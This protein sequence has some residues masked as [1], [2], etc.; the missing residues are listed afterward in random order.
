M[1]RSE[2]GNGESDT[3]T[4]KANGS[5]NAALDLEK[6]SAGNGL[7]REFADTIMSQVT[8]SSGPKES[9][10]AA[11]EAAGS[12]HG[13]RAKAT[14]EKNLATAEGEARRSPTAAGERANGA[15]RKTTDALTGSGRAP[16]SD[17][18]PSGTQLLNQLKV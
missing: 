9:E 7:S 8:P 11:V 3:K 17:A 6:P 14:E 12:S 1:L 5:D 10:R 4:N 13:E 18:F 15:E 16:I 2:I